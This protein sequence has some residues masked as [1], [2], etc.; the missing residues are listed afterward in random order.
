[1]SFKCPKCNGKGYLLKSGDEFNDSGMA[2]CTSCGGSGK[3]GWSGTCSTCNG[4]G[5]VTKPKGLMEGIFGR[6]SKGTVVCSMCGGRG[7]L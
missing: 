5:I 4:L 1:M 7:T 2:R 6:G 3:N